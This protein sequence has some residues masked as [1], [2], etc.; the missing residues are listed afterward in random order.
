MAGLRRSL[1]VPT[2]VT[3]GQLGHGRSDFARTRLSRDRVSLGTK[4]VEI[5]LFQIDVRH[6]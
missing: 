6:F 4:L 3:A 2:T 1:K 5:C